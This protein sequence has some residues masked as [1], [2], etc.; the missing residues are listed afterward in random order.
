MKNVKQ[1]LF[2]IACAGLACVAN[3]DPSITVQFDN[4]IFGKLGYDVV[5]LHYKQVGSQIEES[6]RAA[7][8]RFQGVGSEVKG[9][10][11]TIFVDGLSNLY[12]YCYDVYQS[13]G[14]G[15][16]V[17]YT[18]AFDGET[19]RTRDFLGAVNSVL[20]KDKDA[21]SHDP[22]AWLHPVNGYQGA[23]IQLGIWESL[24]EA[25]DNALSLA[26]GAF[27]ANGIE[28]GNQQIP[29]TQEY[30]AE[31]FAAVDSADALLDKDVIVFRNGTY[32][33]MITG[34]PIPEPGTLALLGAAL[35]GWGLARRKPAPK[36]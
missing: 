31:F 23:A 19:E 36:V 4:P 7:A 25:S 12:M 15:Y 35:V 2:S 16:K 20:N 9:V 21:A 34:D 33:D 13:I 32:Q 3:A 26:S 14:H 1:I 8:G 28:T 10:P 29:K 18:I 5:Q 6:E 11:D 17:N 24:Y 22:F 30:L 27:W